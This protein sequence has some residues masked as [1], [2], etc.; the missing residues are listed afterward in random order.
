LGEVLG[1]RR[2]GL[3]QVGWGDGGKRHYLHEKYLAEDPTA[4]SLGVEGDRVVER[5]PLQ[6]QIDERQ[7]PFRTGGD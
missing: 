4:G 3:R 1:G 2:T 6:Q 5:P 7:V